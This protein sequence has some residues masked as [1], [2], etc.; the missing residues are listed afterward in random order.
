MSR[1]LTEAQNLK[2]DLRA[3]AAVITAAAED[4]L[5]DI[6]DGGEWS[7]RRASARR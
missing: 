4:A 5:N 7:A 3:E 1:G 6:V 2:F